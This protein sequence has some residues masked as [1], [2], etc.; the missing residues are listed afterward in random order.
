MSTLHILF[1]ASAAGTLRQVLTV[2]GSGDEVVGFADCLAMGPIA[3]GDPDERAAW[4]EAH[5]PERFGWGW[6]AD[7]T[8]D[9]LSAI[10]AWRGKRLVWIA[11]Q[12][13]CE[14]CGLQWFFEQVAGGAAGPMIIADAPLSGGWR[15]APPLGLGELPAELVAGLLDRAPR[16]QWPDARAS[17]DV[18]RRLRGEDG[19]LRIVERGALR[20]VAEDHFDDLLLGSC[21][22]EWRKWSRV[23]GDA[24]T[25]A[26]ERSH[27]TG[28]A[29]YLWRLRELVRLGRIECRGELPGR[30]HDEK[31]RPDALLR[32]ALNGGAHAGLAF[33]R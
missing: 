28:D 22:G 13:A 20:T 31:R 10:R 2:R 12:S 16:R 14:Q 18:W 11:P 29:F 21:S 1:S 7:S 15:D 17:G 23:V 24:M 25:K 27:H 9:F 3:G 30:Q 33:S 6:I 32:T 5:V 8:R 26:M 19:L 4:F